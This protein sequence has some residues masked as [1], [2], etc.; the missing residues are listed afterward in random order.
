MSQ[1]IWKTNT[2]SKLHNKQESM[3]FY[4]ILRRHFT[5]LPEKKNPPKSS[6]SALKTKA[7]LNLAVHVHTYTLWRIFH[8]SRKTP[9]FSYLICSTWRTQ[10]SIWHLAMRWFGAMCH[11]MTGWERVATEM[12]FS[13]KQW[14]TVSL[15]ELQSDFSPQSNWSFSANVLPR[16]SQMLRVYFVSLHQQPA[17]L[18]VCVCVCECVFV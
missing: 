2:N 1:W 12:R 8:L 16:K 17:S 3:E 11:I 4:S 9:D 7:M 10:P 13:H 15:L 5:W 18:R 14:L 6:S